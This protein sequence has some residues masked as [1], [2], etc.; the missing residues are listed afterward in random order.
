MKKELLLCVRCSMTVSYTHLDVYKRQHLGHANWSVGSI[1]GTSSHHHNPFVILCDRNT[2][3]TYGNCYGYAPVSYT[4]LFKYGNVDD[5][6]YQKQII[7][8]FINSIYVFDDKLAF[9]YNFKDGTETITLAEIQAAFGSDLTQVAPPNR[10][11]TN[12]YFFSG[13]FAVKCSL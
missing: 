1:R 4:H 3:E 5:P 8:T 2:E 12:T 11:W 7:D 10:Y 13:G 9:T 6:Q